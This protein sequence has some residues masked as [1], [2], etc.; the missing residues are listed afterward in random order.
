MKTLKLLII[1]ILIAGLFGS[2]AK[3][4][5]V[6]GEPTKVPNVN[7]TSHDGYPQISR[8]GLEMY[9]VSM[10]DHSE[11][12]WV[13]KRLTIQEPWSEPV[14][15]DA[16]VNTVRP[17]VSPSLSA[18]GLELYFDRKD[19]DLWVSTRATK[20]DPWGEPVKLESPINTGNRE[21]HPCISADG[22]ELYFRS[23]RPGGDNNPTNSDIFV[24]TRLTKDDPWGEPVKLSTNVNG[25]QYE[26]LPFISPDGLSLF[27]SRGYSKGHVHVC[28]RASIT[29]PWEPA[30]FFAPVN[31][32]TGIWSDSPGQSEFCVSFSEEDSTIYF[33]RGTD[34]FSNDWNIWQ[35][36]VTPVVDFNSDGFVDAM[37]VS[38]MVD[39]WHT[40]E[41]L[42]D[43]APGPMGDG[44]VDSQDLAVLSEYVSP[45]LT[46][47]WALDE[48]EGIVAA[49]SNGSQGLAYDGYIMGGAV[50]EPSGGMI[51]G[52]LRFD[53]I[54][55]YIINPAVV[56]PAK[57]HFSLFL[58]IQGGAPGQV[59]I[60]EPLGP[61]WL[62]LDEG[63]RFITELTS[64]DTSGG[65]LVSDTNITDGFWHHIGLVWDGSSRKLCVDGV[66]VAE[67]MQDTLESPSNSLYIGTNG[68]SDDGTF[69]SGLI[70]DIRVFNRALT[71]KQ[72][73]GFV[74]A[75]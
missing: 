57:E 30:E 4:D 72:S 34:V 62:S 8:D 26:T 11:D 22:L 12:I 15:L 68:T 36:E 9:F 67:D 35:V 6:F 18:D 31:S 29:D 69:F 59:V 75:R 23:N 1:L 50:W 66:I 64:S 2:V 70:D 21:D 61:N 46:A 40:N 39:F 49:N 74:S 16:P 10:R 24:T 27:F 44:F 42:C 41:S 19:S 58:W 63:G 51:G 13:S 17:E 71:E 33:A 47:H 56:N 3:A 5:F 55:D 54:D 32:A 73:K 20:D 28:R 48:S 60:S 14:K 37:D 53:G 65:P 7:S 25:D 52:A 45:P 38:I 43:I